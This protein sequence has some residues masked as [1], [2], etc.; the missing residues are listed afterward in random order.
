[1]CACVC[2]FPSDCVF[3][4][5]AEQGS[6]ELRCASYEVYAVACQEAGVKLGP[7]RERLGCGK[8]LNTHI[9]TAFVYCVGILARTEI[10]D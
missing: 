4:L 5:C 2:V 1:M 3:D 7:W 6:A 8:I 9:H 10:F